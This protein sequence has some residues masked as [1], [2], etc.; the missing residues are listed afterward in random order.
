M[1]WQHLNAN[2]DVIPSNHSWFRKSKKITFTKQLLFAV[3]GYAAPG[4]I[5]AIM[6]SSGAGMTFE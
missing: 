1:S 2:V 6:G 5:V 3:N 4:K